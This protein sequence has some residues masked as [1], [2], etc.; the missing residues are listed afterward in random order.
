M[1]TRGRFVAAEYAKRVGDLF[2]PFAL[3]DFV[4]IYLSSVVAGILARPSSSIGPFRCPGWTCHP[5][6]NESVVGDLK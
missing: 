5:G 6:I 2:S 3:R 1:D 4:G